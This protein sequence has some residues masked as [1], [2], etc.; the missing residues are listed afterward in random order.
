MSAEQLHQLTVRRG[1]H[2]R[3]SELELKRIHWTRTASCMMS[4]SRPKKDERARWRSERVL[5]KA[6]ECKHRITKGRE[7]IVTGLSW[8]SKGNWKDRRQVIHSPELPAKVR[9]R[10]ASSFLFLSLSLHVSTYSFSFD[11]F[12]WSN[13]SLFIK[14]SKQQHHHRREPREKKLPKQTYP[15]LFFSFFRS[16]QRSHRDHTSASFSLVAKRLTQNQMH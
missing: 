13:I 3:T 10:Q 11:L 12:I 4:R 14:S 2:N 5:S 7:E 8:K 6:H 1:W 16:S 9:R 15:H